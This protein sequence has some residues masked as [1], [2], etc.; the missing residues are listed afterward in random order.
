MRFKLIEYDIIVVLRNIKII[1][2]MRISQTI[3]Q[4]SNFNT[5]KLVLIRSIFIEC[6]STFFIELKILMN[7]IIWISYKIDFKNNL[8]RV[9]L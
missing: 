3:A 5:T 6:V 9:V 8:I 4:D 1:F 2:K 7:L